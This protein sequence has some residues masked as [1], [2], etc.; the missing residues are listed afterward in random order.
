MHP[1]Q[2]LQ[3]LVLPA[4]K[5]FRF[6]GPELIAVPLISILTRST[7]SLQT[8]TIHSNGLSIRD[9]TTL[10]TLTPLLDELDITPGFPGLVT[11]LLCT[12]SKPPLVPALRLLTIHGTLS[13]RLLAVLKARCDDPATHNVF[14]LECARLVFRPDD[15]RPPPDHPYQLHHRDAKLLGWHQRLDDNLF[16][17]RAEVSPRGCRHLSVAY[18]DDLISLYPLLTPSF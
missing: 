13:S 11:P 2:L 1:P 15:N 10:L 8:L 18:I 16:G 14:R 6:R 7:C 17:A 9:L 12:E 5:D 3:G 4:L